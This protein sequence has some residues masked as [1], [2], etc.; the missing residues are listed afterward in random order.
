M[1]I[2]YS[3]DSFDKIKNPVVTTGTFDGVHVGHSIIINRLNQLA[4]E[5]DGESVLI[6]FHPHPRKVLFPEQSKDLKLINTQNEKKKM[7]AKTGLHH[8]FIISF[9]LEFSKTSSQSFV[10]D[11]LL[12]KLNAKIIVVGFNHHFGHNR[13][14]DY[15][16]L[17]ELSQKRN[18][19]VEEIPQQDIENEAVSSTR[20]RK[21][22]FEG[23][24]MKANAYLDHQYFI[25]GRLREFDQK[26]NSCCIEIEE[27][28][29]LLPPSGR[30][31]AKLEQDGNL[32]NCFCEINQTTVDTAV[33]IFMG[34][35]AMDLSEDYANLYFYKK[36]R[37]FPDCDLD[38]S[39]SRDED[40]Q[41]LNELIF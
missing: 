34:E 23:Q 38:F 14:G 11:I 16:Y 35:V 22:I 39:V 28:E 29:K 9:T 20:I 31:A 21:A 8:L 41:L 5:I 15:D 33:K 19:G 12:D 36:L 4:A 3:F 17:Y 1:K 40:T 27:S 26:F 25:M 6:T 10:N 2:H 7:L 37:A 24:I 13:Q 32:I 30:Y 18:F